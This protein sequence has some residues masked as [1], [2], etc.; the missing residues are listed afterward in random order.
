MK[1]LILALSLATIFT[2]CVDESESKPQTCLKVE[3]V[4]HQEPSSHA[5]SL[6]EVR[7]Q[8]TGGYERIVVNSN[9]ITPLF[10]NAK[11]GDILCY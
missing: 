5:L 4:A 10:K 1:K 2:S 7:N 8:T 6:F 11:V 9:E 3:Q